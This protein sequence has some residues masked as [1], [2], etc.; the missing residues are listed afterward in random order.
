MVQSPARSN[1]RRANTLHPQTQLGCTKGSRSRTPER[2]G[3]Q[4]RPWALADDFEH[5]PRREHRRRE[6]FVRSV[7]VRPDVVQKGFVGAL[8]QQGSCR[9]HDR[10]QQ[11]RRRAT[12][13]RGC[14][15]RC[16]REDEREPSSG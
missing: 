6:P 12:A 11:E 3:A 14:R 16:T 1:L 2:R 10:H 4:P 15:R 9:G 5:D 13:P 7:V 8:Q